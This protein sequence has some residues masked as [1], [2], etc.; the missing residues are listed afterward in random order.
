MHTDTSPTAVGDRM[1]PLN[2]RI[3]RKHLIVDG[4]V[5]GVAVVI[6]SLVTALVFWAAKR[7]H[8]GL[9]ETD[10]HIDGHAFRCPRPSRPTAEPSRSSSWASSRRAR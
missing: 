5:A 6:A 9:P 7:L 2:R 8:R 1:R 10:V 3:L 4:V